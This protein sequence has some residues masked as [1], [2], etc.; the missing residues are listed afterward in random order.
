MLQPLLTLIDAPVTITISATEDEPDARP[1][2]EVV[3]DSHRGVL[4]KDSRA[5]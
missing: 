5:T 2:I 3:G 1:S 4:V